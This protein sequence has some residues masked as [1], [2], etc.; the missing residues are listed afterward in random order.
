[1]LKGKKFIIENYL[2]SAFIALKFKFQ[3][4]PGVLLLD[5][6]KKFRP[7]MSF[8]RKRMGRRHNPIPFP[9]RYRRQYLLS[10]KHVTQFIRNAT[11][12]NFDNRLISTLSTLF[13]T[14]RNSITRTIATDVKFLAEARFF[15]HLR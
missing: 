13:E 2:N 15:S 4:L 12:R 14:A 8:I 5:Q 1:M 6:I 3:K 11:D 9:I 10:I 7:V